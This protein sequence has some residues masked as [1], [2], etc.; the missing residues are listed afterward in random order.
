MEQAPAISWPISIVIPVAWGDMDSFQHVNNT[1]YLKWFESA[2]IA[3]FEASG[4]IERMEQDQVGPIL[5]STSINY[6][7]AVR[8]PDTVTAWATVTE[9]RNTS[10]MMNYKITS[11]QQNNKVVA[12]GTGA[13]VMLDYKTGAKEPLGSELRSQ[14]ERLQNL[15]TSGLA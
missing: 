6:R 8:F 2:R 14:I 1:I 4:V 3:Y 11:A 15:N 5:A 13:I 10:F 12:D 9:L 7:S